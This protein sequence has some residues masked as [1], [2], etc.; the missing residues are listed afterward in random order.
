M[1]GATKANIADS[2][3]YTREAL[4]KKGENSPAGMAQAARA[5]VLCIS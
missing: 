5:A 2:S 3:V 1:G 4:G